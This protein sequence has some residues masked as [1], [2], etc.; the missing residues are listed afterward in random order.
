M[1][2]CFPLL[3]ARAV[4]KERAYVDNHLHFIKYNWKSLQTFLANRQLSS[5]DG[6][7]T[8]SPN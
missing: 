5:M 2:N 3:W 1:A 8:F 6:K 7:E 4:E